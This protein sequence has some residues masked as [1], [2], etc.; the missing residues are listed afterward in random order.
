MKI[1]TI[2]INHMTEPLGFEYKSLHV[3]FKVEAEQFETV[4]KQVEI[5]AG[6][7]LVH[8]SDF[9]PFDSNSFELNL[10]LAPRTRYD[11][12]VNLKTT[13]GQTISATSFFETGKMTEAF[14][15]KWIANK[16]KE[17][18]NTLFRKIVSVAK[19]V[20]KARLYMTALGVYETFIDGQKVGHEFLA[21]G[22]TAY[23]QWVQLQ[24][25]DV[26][27]AFTQGDHELLIS[28][29]DGWF[30]GAY[31]FI[32]GIDCIYGDQHRALAEYH[33]D[34]EDGG[35]EIISTDASWETTAGRVSKSA[36]YYGEDRD[37]TKEITD[38]EP[39]VLVEG[40]YAVLTDRLSLPL[41]VKETLDVVEVLN[42]PAGETVLDFG[43]NHA[44]LFR[45]YNRLPK[46]TK[47]FLQVGEILQEGNFYKENL[48]SARAAFEYISDGEEKWVQPAFTYYGFRYMKVEGFDVIHPEDFKADVI[49]SDMVS[50]GHI[51]T[52][53]A[54]VNRLF[55]N[56]IW[57]Q[58]GNFFDVPTDCPQRDERLGWSG[59]ANVFSN[60][61]LFNMDVYAFYRKYLKDLAI[62]QDLNDGRSPMY[63]PSFGNP[64]GGGAIWGDATTVVPW[65]VYQATGDASILT[66]HYQYMKAWVDWIGRQTKTQNLWTGG[67]QFGDWLALD[68]ENPAMPTGKTDEDFIASIY[69]HYSAHIVAETAKLLENDADAAYYGQ[70]SAA[71]L[72]AIRNEYISANGRLTIDTQTAYALTLQFDLVP[73]TLRERVTKDLVARLHKDDD[74]L[75]TGFVGT[76]FIN[77]MLSQFGQHQLATKI[78]LLEDLPS[79]L[80]AVN[81]GATTIWERWN[82]VEPDGSMNPEGM[83]SLNHYSIGA[84]MEWAY[85]YVVGIRN[86]QKGYQAF[87]IAPEFDYRLDQISGEFD[88]P[89][90]PISVSY[91]IESDDNHTIKMVIKVPFGSTAHVTLPRSENVAVMVNGDSRQGGQFDL[92]AGHY[93]ISYVPSQNYI[94]HYSAETTAAEIMADDY[95]IEQIDAI[96]PV[97]DFFRK[98]PDAV[99]GGL[100]K[101]SLTKLNAILPFI[102]IS[103]EH[104]KQ[105]NTVLEATP[106]LAQRHS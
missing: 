59:D 58:K 40:D 20:A 93:D 62:E 88:S 68:G 11:V 57:G 94:E 2:T 3:G 29:A 56:V 46:G 7:S 83:N 66:E 10:D 103:D 23:D 1:T 50:T 65:N 45:F 86:P 42:T 82:S 33:I 101:M 51:T 4:E 90:G 104:L 98:D 17:I 55:E 89:Y 99:H 12:I 27:S 37:D 102:T 74:H 79:W 44:G 14:E 72:D 31:G 105:I 36:I 9:M 71:I 19:P 28:T 84:I 95:L 41:V 53:N 16:D 43:Q 35:S 75:K 22:Q 73:E 8:R 39:V 97:L 52:N 34:Y 61:A 38:W 25:Y 69:Y 49:Y 87:D 5:K 26:T 85:K 6:D 15:A 91:R 18:Q 77:Q 60:T 67:F 32:E 21:P 81:M 80:Y 54:K 48:R 63:A 76:P 96:D 30:K 100:G 92:T 24:T 78:F 106:I 13:D 70:L 47:V 64:D